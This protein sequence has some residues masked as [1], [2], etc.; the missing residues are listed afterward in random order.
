MARRPLLRCLNGDLF[1]AGRPYGVVPGRIEYP[2]RGALRVESS[3][4]TAK[5]WEPTPTKIGKWEEVREVQTHTH[6]HTHTIFYERCNS[7]NFQSDKT[8][9][10]FVHGNLS[11]DLRFYLTISI[12]KGRFSWKISIFECRKTIKKLC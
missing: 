2:Y 12:D 1:L 9:Y 4:K 11:C 7:T 10:E 8:F 5:K 3:G 6:T